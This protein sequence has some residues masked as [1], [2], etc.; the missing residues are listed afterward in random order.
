MTVRTPALADIP[1]LETERLIL[2]APEAADF[3]AF[4]DFAL[5]DR[6]HYV[7]GGPEHNTGYA[8]RVLATLAGHWHLRGFGIYVA[9][10]KTTGQPIGSM[11][12]WFP[13]NWPEPELSWTIWT[14]A[15]EG[16]GYAFEAVTTLRHHA[17][18]VLGW[19]TAVSYID[20]GNARS[21]ALAQRLGCQVDEGA[22]Q[23]DFDDPVEVW[24]HPGPE[25]LK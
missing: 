23:P 18:T 9:Q 19:I 6:A 17:Y 7:G 15:A 11:G 16:Q 21:R 20:P 10:E 5:S 13:G 1:H 14:E 12:P 3:D 24:R 8:W 22:A 25:D 2:R 4:A